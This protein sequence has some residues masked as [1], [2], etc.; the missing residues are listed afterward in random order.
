MSHVGGRNE[1]LFILAAFNLT[2]VHSI[3]MKKIIFP[4]AGAPQHW[5]TQYL[6]FFSRVV[7]IKIQTPIKNWIVYRFFSPLSMT[8]ADF[9]PHLIKQ[10][11]AEMHRK[12]VGIGGGLLGKHKQTNNIEQEYTTQCYPAWHLGGSLQNWTDS[13]QLTTETV[14]QNKQIIIIKTTQS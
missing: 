3:F 7:L 4:P 14:N 9:L 11:D 1:L 13:H 10:H 2:L 8:L 6:W 5:S 12:E